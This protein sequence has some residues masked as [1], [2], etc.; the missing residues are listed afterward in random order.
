MRRAV[1]LAVL[2]LLPRLAGADGLTVL[3]VAKFAAFK[4]GRGTVLVGRDPQLATPPVPTCP[5]TSAVELSSYPEPTQRVVVAT[6]VVLDCTKWRGK[7]NGFT[8]ND[9]AAPGGVRSIRYGRA[10]LRIRFQG[11]PMPTGPVGYVQ[12]WLEVG[13]TRF[14]ARFHNFRRNEPGTLISRVPSDAAATGERAFWAVLHH[15]WE[16]PAEKAALEATALDCFVRA[17]RADLRDGRSRFLLA[18]THL[19]RFGQAVDRYET[20][21]DFARG[22]IE[23]ARAAFQQA[24]PL[25]WDGSVGDSRVPGFAAATTFTLG[26]IRNDRAMQ[27]QGLAELDEA[28]RINPFFNLFDYLPVIQAVP[29]FD[30]RFRAVFDRVDRYLADPDTLACL[31]T[32]PELCADAGY[33]PANSTG[34]LAL[35]GDLNAKAG[36]TPGARQWY[37][38]S[39]ALANAR[40]MPYRFLPAAQERVATVDQRVALFGDTV[41]ANDPT[42]TG[43]GAEACAVC[44][45]R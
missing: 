12:A 37:S 42:V 24:L 6:R 11:I 38:L 33:A 36:D 31:S 15:D 43:A 28:F 3:T 34:A 19:Y 1:A 27:D 20:I 32:Q 29:A 35:F 8:Y 41:P 26:V 14:N 18:M 4:A 39:L 44:H 16:T 21:S 2:A 7:R 13:T 30:P 25:L 45:T 10:G 22:E 9:P 17:A 40:P 5:T 23:A